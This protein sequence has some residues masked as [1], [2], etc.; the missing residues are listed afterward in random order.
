MDLLEVSNLTS[1]KRHCWEIERAIFFENLIKKFVALDDVTHILDIGC[2][3]GYFSNI[4]AKRYTSDVEKKTVA[5]DIELTP[6]KIAALNEHYKNKNL[7]FTRENP[8]ISAEL[9]VCMDVCEHVKD[10]QEFLT[11][12]VKAKLTEK[13]WLLFTVPAWP[14]LFGSHDVY[15]KHFRRYTPS[16][17]RL[18]IKNSGLDIVARGGLFFSL[19]LPRA[20]SV[21]SEKI[22]SRN[23]VSHKS[24]LMQQEESIASSLFLPPILK[25]DRY[26]CELMATMQFQIPG[27]TWWALCKKV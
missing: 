16:Q 7:I 20:L 21:L 4:L 25:A 23:S 9:I 14:V 18:L 22:S 15:L 8:D 26:I 12:L 27:L 13:G 19:I 11:S 5:W 2:G 24:Q 3:D 17:A 10:D 1:Q 6:Q